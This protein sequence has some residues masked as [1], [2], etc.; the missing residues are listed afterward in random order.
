[1][2][3][4]CVASE[5]YPL[6]KTGGLADVAGALPLA[7]AQFGVQARVLLPGYPGMREQL[8]STRR[9]ASLPR[10]FGGDGALVSGTLP[11]GSSG[12]GLQ[13]W[14]VE[15]PHLYNRKGGGPYLGP[16][17][18]DWPD[19]HLR[20]AALSWVG[21]QIGLGRLGGWHPDVA[22]LHDWQAALTAAYLRFSTNGSRSIGARTIGAPAT[23]LT[24]HNLA[25]QGLFPAGLLP[26][27]ELPPAALEPDGMEYWG[28]LSFLKAGV[29]WCD[30][31]STVSPTYAREIL[32][33]EQGMGFDG[34]LRSRPER[35]TGIVN[36]IDDGVW[37]PANDP[38]LVAPYS[39][40]RVAS[41]AA[42]KAALQVELG[43]DVRVDAPLFCVVSRLTHQKGLDLLLAA[44]PRLLAAGAQ[45]AALGSGDRELEDG[46]RRVAELHHGQVAAIIGYDEPLSHRLQAGSDAIIV[47]S[48]FEPCGLTQLYGLR[49]GTLPVVS[50]VGGLADT[51]IDA[52]EA[53]LRDGVATGF[54]FSPV[55]AG[56]L[57]DAIERATDLF[58]DTL[59]WQRVVKRAM[60]RDVG[61]GVAAGAYMALYERLV[62][63][64]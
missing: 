42:N 45:L 56:Q 13:V 54:Q 41:K 58:A 3:V 14:L 15:A 32:A 53:G 2:K 28:S 26:T 43:L 44:M 25:F 49:Y 19:N 6:V 55:A 33:P 47:P 34:V 48:R 7:L 31:V 37:N 62:A 52:N 20:F 64:R 30:G 39:A 22:H 18:K 16:D 61:W 24:I 12:E 21:A 46:F 60:T 38:A 59:A 50:R 63:G 8:S 4:L 40:R 29:Q 1:M 27:L 51:I 57:G 17:G 5:C 11:T 23:L 10:L 36:G 35:L 9:I